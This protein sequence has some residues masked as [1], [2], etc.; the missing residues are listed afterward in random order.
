LININFWFS[1]N[2]RKNNVFFSEI[3]APL[4][5]VNRS[6]AL[7]LQRNIETN[8]LFYLPDMKPIYLLLIGILFPFLL[9]AQDK[10][11][12]K[13]GVRTDSEIPIGIQVDALAPRIQAVSIDG[14]HIDTDELIKNGPVVVMFYRGEWCPVCNK[15]LSEMNES[16]PSIKAKG[17]VVLAIGPELPENAAKTKEATASDFIFIADTSLQILKD[18]DVLFDVTEKYQKKI[19]T[20]LSTDIAENNGK[21]DAQLPVPAT[22]IIS[23]EGV[24]IYKQ[25]D[26][27]YKNRA[28]AEDI[29]EHL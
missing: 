2:I 19:R 20:F 17:A 16:L 29:L 14:E 22:F 26:L 15:Y 13:Y 28:S 21:E 6:E 9:F 27:N 12:T 25:F 11:P 10:D 1:K 18:Y 8:P 7:H 5:K 24:I 23:Q 3:V 4:S